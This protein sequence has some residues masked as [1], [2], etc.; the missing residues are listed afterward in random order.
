MDKCSCSMSDEFMATKLAIKKSTD[1]K[2]EKEW[3]MFYTTV[4]IL[5]LAREK[6][7]YII[8][9][10]SGRVYLDVKSVR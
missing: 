8:Q 4:T 3:R 6:I 5:M 2:A 7:L 9:K 10:P 1:W